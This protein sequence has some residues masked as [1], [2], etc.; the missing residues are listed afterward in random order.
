MS[1]NFPSFFEKIGREEKRVIREV[2]KREN[3]TIKGETVTRCSRACLPG[4]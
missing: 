2:G 1:Y 4:T 3:A